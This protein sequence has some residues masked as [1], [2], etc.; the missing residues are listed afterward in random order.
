M[1]GSNFTERCRQ[2]LIPSLALG[3]MGR[4][5]SEEASTR[6]AFQN[7]A[8]IDRAASDNERSPYVVTARYHSRLCKRASKR[9]DGP[10]RVAFAEACATTEE[11]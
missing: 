5:W 10:S 11:S 9:C 2:V 4:I 1:P 6:H 8:R 7:P 3:A